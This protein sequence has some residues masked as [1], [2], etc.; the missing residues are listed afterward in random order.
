MNQYYS[1]Q[2]NLV[3]S[4][5]DRANSGAEKLLLEI[6]RDDLRTSSAHFLVLFSFRRMVLNNWPA[7]CDFLGPICGL[8]TKAALLGVKLGGI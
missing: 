4:I 5:R 6:S 7:Q 2:L 3:A 1:T 8:A